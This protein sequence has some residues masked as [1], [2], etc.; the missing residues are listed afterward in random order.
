MT[1]FSV[2]PG[3][4]TV[5][6]TRRL[7]RHLRLRHGLDQAAAGRRVWATPDC[8][9]WP[10]LI[11]KLFTEGRHT[12]GPSLRWLGDR[13]ARLVWER[14]VRDDPVVSDLIGLRGLGPLAQRSWRLLHE[15]GIPLA[16]LAGEG[17]AESEAFARWSQRYARW[18]NDHARVDLATAVSLIDPGAVNA[19]IQLTGFDTLTP[20]QQ[21]FVAR[22]RGA[23]A[24]VDVIAQQ[25]RRGRTQK[26]LCRDSRAEYEAAARWA[27]AAVDM[28]PDRQVA[29]VV[30]NLDQVRAEVRRAFDAIFCPEASRSGGP[31]PE[32]RGYELAAARPLLD[33]PVVTSACECLA[34]FCRPFDTDASQ[35]LLVNPHLASDIEVSQRATLSLTIA[36]S[37]NGPVR[38]SFLELQS[39]DAGCPIF[40]A[41]VRRALLEQS[42]W[43][44]RAPPSAWAR[45][46]STLLKHMQWA[47][48]RLD[49][50]EYQTRERFLELLAELGGL[51]DL[52]G[53]ISAPAALSV[54]RDLAEAVQFEGEEVP[55][56]VLVID[57]ATCAGMQFDALW[58]VGLEA[59]QWPAPASVDPLLPRALQVRYELAGC[60]AQSA[61]LGSRLTLQRLCAA[62][63]EVMLSVPMFEGDAQLLPSAL[64]AAVPVCIE[65]PQQWPGATPDLHLFNAR[66]P[67]IHTTDR[68]LPPIGEQER[69]RG[70]AAVLEL[71]SACPFRAGAELR[72]GARAL[73]VAA[74][75]IDAVTRGTLLHAIVADLW[76]SLRDSQTLLMLTEDERASRIREAIEGRLLRMQETASPVIQHLLGLEARWLERE[77]L[78]LMQQEA[79]RSPFTVEHV[80]LSRTMVLGGLELELRIDRVDRFDD[81]LLA[82]IDYKTGAAAQRGAWLEER[83]KLPQLPLYLHAIGATQV[84]A[85][86]FARVRSGETGLN[87]LARDD[88]G[89]AGV[90]VP[91]TRDLHLAWDELLQQWY[92]RLELIAIE[93]ASGDA[94]LAPDPRTACK[95][96]HLA[97]LC[98]IN[99]ASQSTATAD[100]DSNE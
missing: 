27:A 14:I 15:Y 88:R 29:V 42:T 35:G 61:A 57:P 21:G 53:Q 54:L 36:R 79:R 47:E 84:A 30:P 83:P 62:A 41:A 5:T 82:V 89:I 72:L 78:A 46:F 95:Y 93:Y 64:L 16:A 50:A 99:E 49:S 85:V 100:D 6:P 39:R 2:L 20:Q 12:G 26:I 73:P 28:A 17:G 4:L 22:M 38:V 63:D 34:V 96:C 44:E 55:A 58:L 13:E 43:Q 77:L 81:G 40:A 70:G 45:S 1:A 51:D 23:G 98:R 33:A 3:M 91:P 97:A 67:L 9:S 80:E 74:K 87:G 10:T 65:P 24:T 31:A 48:G 92:Q 94:R 52:M 60:T 37:S 66:P 19:R 56:P 68:W 32:S 69:R 86:A 7:A 76:Q 59:T 25:P 18:L 71:Q 75:G 8:V 11:E 90:V